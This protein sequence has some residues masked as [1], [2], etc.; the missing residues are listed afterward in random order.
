MKLA[1][2]QT[3]WQTDAKIDLTK[4]AHAAASVPMLHAKYVSLMATARLS[5]RKAESELLS[6]K[7]LKE[8]YYRG[9]LSK[10]ELEE[11]GWEQYLFNKP[12]KAELESIILADDEYIRKLEKVE[13]LRTILLVLESILKS[14]NNRTWD[15][16][17]TIEY[18]KFEAGS[19]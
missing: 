2:I 13:Y 6:F 9:E 18:T 14:I 3:M 11:Y 17:S 15:I 5:V 8:R 4:L 7:K 1:D 12:L 19:Y 10:E 16:K